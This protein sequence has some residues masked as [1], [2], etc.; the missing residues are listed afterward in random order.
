[1]EKLDDRLSQT[2]TDII[3]WI[4]KER[5][6]LSYLLILCF[7]SFAYELFNFTLTVDEEFYAERSGPILNNEWVRQGRWSMYLL[8]YLYP[9]NPIVPFA[10]LFFTLVCSALAF[11]IVV[12]LFSSNRTIND[13]WAA[14]LFI[15]CPTLYY[16]YSFN[17]L[18]FGIGIGFLAGALAI[19]LF[20]FRRGM[21]RWFVPAILIAFSIGIYQ[22]FLPWILVLFCFSALRLIF[23]SKVTFKEILKTFISFIGLLVSGLVFYYLISKGFRLALKLNSNDYIDGFVKY[24]LSLDYLLQTFKQTLYSMKNHYL[25]KNDIYDQN[26]LSL[27][28]LFFTTLLSLIFQVLKTK[29]PLSTK[30]LGL[31][32]VL[33]ILATPFSLNLI[34]AGVMPTR[35]LLAVPLVLSGFVFLSLSASSIV[36][37]FLI[38]LLVC[39]T[40]FQFITIN[41]RFAFADYIS[42]QADRALSMRILNR[43]DELDYGQENKTNSKRVYALV[44]NI[45]RPKY[46][47]I[48]ERQTIGASFYNWDQGNVHRVLSLMRSMGIDEYEP[49]TLEQQRSIMQFADTMPIWPQAGSVALKNGVS[50]VK[51]GNYTNSQLVPLCAGTLPCALC[52]IIYNPGK[53]GIRI[54]DEDSWVDK[55]KRERVFQLNDNLSEAQF[56]NATYKIEGDQIVL[57]ASTPGTQIILPQIKPLNVDRVLMRIVL[58]APQDTT[59]FLFYRYPGETDYTGSNQI[60]VKLYKGV[61]NLLF[62]VPVQLLEESLRFDPGN[63]PGIYQIIKLEMYKPNEN[64]L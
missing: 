59:M 24:N 46:S 25:G 8:S 52:R 9:I 40:T 39:A 27:L 22:A 64:S 20:T 14:P 6:W 5:Y 36:L 34:S 33:L 1:M 62:S 42:W 21:S 45:S 3:R 58:D 60:Q 2:Q 49:A 55:D 12:R 56:L 37:R 26:I 57:N 23:E 16:V 32:I 51:L 13:F 48:V 7:T 28:L 44:G 43:L 4:K 29:Q 15:A 30:L 41:N 11:S 19:Y 10:P 35:A 17:T 61:N 18:N 47:L 50:I 31:L 53:G 54:L 63:I 38:I